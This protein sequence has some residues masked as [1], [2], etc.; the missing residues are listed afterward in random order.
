M[1]LP[2]RLA[3]V[4]LFG[5]AA[6]GSQQPTPSPAAAETESPPRA[7]LPP[8]LPTP[9]PAPTPTAVAISVVDVVQLPARETGQ[10]VLAVRLSGG[11][12][13]SA[14]ER[15]LEISAWMEPINGSS[16]EHP[17]VPSVL[18]PIDPDAVQPHLADL[19]RTVVV[20]SRGGQPARGA[21]S[22]PSARF[23]YGPVPSLNGEFSGWVS[24]QFPASHDGGFCAF[25][26]R[27]VVVVVARGTASA[28]LPTVR[29]DTRDRLDGSFDHV[30]WAAR[31]DD[32]EGRTSTIGALTADQ[33]PAPPF[34]DGELLDA[35][36]ALALTAGSEVAS[37]RAER[38]PG[39][40]C[41][42]AAWAAS[43]AMLDRWH[44][45]VDGAAAALVDGAVTADEAYADAR[46]LGSSPR[47]ADALERAIGD[48]RTTC[49][50]LESE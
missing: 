21:A 3:L 13:T 25:D 33:L 4:L 32:W 39:G 15:S 10:R 24:F 16:C 29:V 27:G 35:L 14:I 31:L 46:S 7:T 50:D 1:R 47:Q 38:P 2:G 44:A 34:S 9:A 20:R 23:R 45:S 17:P 26:V 28:E 40:V 37:L 19:T 6:C 49:A 22:D 43:V 18:A 48:A 12:G 42:F 41:Y 30:T 11:A 8:Q 5:L 36:G